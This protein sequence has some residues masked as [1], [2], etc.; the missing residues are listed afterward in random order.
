MTCS[1]HT[2]QTSRTAAS[3]DMAELESK[4]PEECHALVQSGYIYVDVRCAEGWGCE[5]NEDGGAWREGFTDLVRFC[6]RT[7]DEFSKAHSPGAINI[8]VMTCP[9]PALP[10]VC[11]PCP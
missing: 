5:R 11:R 8:P 9:C 1:T 7:P 4:T 2:R 10:F 3:P 6:R